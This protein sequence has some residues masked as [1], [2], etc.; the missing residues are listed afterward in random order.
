MKLDDMSPKNYEF[1]CSLIGKVIVMD[2]DISFWPDTL[3]SEGM[4][5]RIT[6]ITQE[7]IGFSVDVDLTEFEAYNDPLMTRE[8]WD[9]KDNYNLTVKEAGLY[10]GRDKIYM[11]YGQD[12]PFYAESEG[13]PVKSKQEQFKAYHI[14]SLKDGELSW[15]NTSQFIFDHDEKGLQLARDTLIFMDKLG[16]MLPEENTKYRIVEI[17]VTVIEGEVK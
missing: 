7:D 12:M 5:G 14:Q 11:N 3:T 9:D 1:A 15:S 17:V 6:A 2:Q 16:A 13:K 10:T 8:F 4:K